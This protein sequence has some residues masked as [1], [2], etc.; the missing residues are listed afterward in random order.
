MLPCRL[1]Q[2]ND[3]RRYGVVSRAFHQLQDES[4]LPLLFERVF[5]P[6]AGTTSA[7]RVF[8]AAGNLAYAEFGHI[9]AQESR[10]LARTGTYP[11][12]PIIGTC[13]N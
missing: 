11:A 1:P 10:A 9:T 7:R 6:D 8:G 5:Q 13:V 3:S 4:K 2:V 12:N